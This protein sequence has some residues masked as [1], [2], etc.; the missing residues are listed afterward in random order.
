MAVE[1]RPVHRVK[2]RET[3]IESF[4]LKDEDGNAIPA[5]SLTSATLTL[6]VVHTGAIVNSR[7]AQNILNA[8]N[9]TIDGTGLLAWTIQAADMAITDDSRRVEVHRALFVF[10]WGSGREKPYEIDYEIENMSKLT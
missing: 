1:T 4:S 5:G 9:V 3:G 7:N 8:N 2:E 10:K 6:H